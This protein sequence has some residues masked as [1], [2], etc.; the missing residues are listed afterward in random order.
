MD[1]IGIPIR[2]T[3]GRKFNDGKVELKLRDQNEIKEVN[4][5]DLLEELKAI[6]K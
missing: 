6:T 1:L 2:V 4:I 5:D 3:I